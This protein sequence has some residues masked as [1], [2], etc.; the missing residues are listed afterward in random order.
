M[1][2]ALITVLF[3]GEVEKS[4][5]LDIPLALTIGQCL[6]QLKEVRWLPEGWNFKCE[7]SRTG[8]KWRPLENQVILAQE[9]SGDG[10]IICIHP[11]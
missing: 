10:G 5:D 8:E 2:T 3:K 7:V 6:E 11:Y 4:L 9:L 1:N